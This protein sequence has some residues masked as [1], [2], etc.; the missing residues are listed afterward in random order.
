MIVY[1]KKVAAAGEHFIKESRSENTVIYDKWVV[2][3]HKFVRNIVVDQGD[4][5]PSRGFEGV[6]G[7]CGYTIER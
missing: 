6:I 4:I 2:S 5:I 7:I 1:I 3:R